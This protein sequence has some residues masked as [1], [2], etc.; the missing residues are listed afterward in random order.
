MKLESNM[1]SL[2][3]KAT[4]ELVS[5]PVAL[6]PPSRTA[7]PAQRPGSMIAD[8]TL[9]SRPSQHPE[10]G[11]WRSTALRVECPLPQGGRVERFA[12]CFGVHTSLCDARN[13][14]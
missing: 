4:W 3:L 9:V 12:G 10:T 8:T 5:C 13:V 1:F 11:Q 2:I 14:R 7:F 6:C